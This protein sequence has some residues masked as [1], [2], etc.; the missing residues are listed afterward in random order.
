MLT[1][2]MMTPTPVSTEKA[3][4]PDLWKEAF[5]SLSTEDQKQYEDCSSSMLSVLKQVCN[6]RLV[7]QTSVI[8][9]ISIDR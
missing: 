6:L 9:K 5:A 3:L 8:W 1:T 2:A 4:K 7:M